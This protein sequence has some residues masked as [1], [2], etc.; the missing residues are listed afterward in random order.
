MHKR[1]ASSVRLSF[2]HFF[3][4]LIFLLVS[5]ARGDEAEKTDPRFTAVDAIFEKAVSTGQIPGAVVLV[6]YKGEIVYRRAFGFRALEPHRQPMTLETV[7]DLASLTK[8][9]AT[10]PS[11]MRMVQ[12]GQVRLNDPV[13]RYLPEF[14][15]NGKE[16]ITVRQLLTHFS[17]LREDLDLKTPW[18]GKQRA[19]EMAFD[20]RPVAPPGSQF[21]YSDINYIAL[22]AV[23]ERISGMS[24]AEYA[25]AHF[26]LPLRMEHTSFLPPRAW[27]PEIAATQ[28]DERG[29]MLRGEVHDPTARRMGGIAGHAGLFS[30]ADDLSRFAQALLDGDKI[31]SPEIIQK[32]TTPQQPANSTI[33]RGLGW[34]IDSPFSSNRGELLPVG[35]YGHTGFTG[36]S[37]WIDPLTQT[38]IIILTNAV[39][40]RGGAN[41]VALR[42]RVA[43]A[44]ADA[45]K[46]EVK[47]EDRAKLAAITGYNETLAG[48]RRLAS[49]N[50]SVLTG[51]D[52]LEAQNFSELHGSKGAAPRRIGVLTNQTGIDSQGRRTIDVL[53]QAPG[54]QLAAIF[55]PEHGATG[56]VDI[57]DIGN[58]VDSGTHVPIYSVY[59]A[60]D[61]QRHPPL[62]VLKDLDAVVIDLQHAGAR[63]YTY[64]TTMGYFL[65]AA[66]KTGIEIIVL[67]RPNPITGSFVQGP[68]S[69]SAHLG[70]VNYYPLPVRHG[71]T[72]GELAKFFNAER[73]L[74]ARLSVVPMQGWMRGDWFDS[75]SVTWVNPSPNL[76]SLNEATLYPGVA[77]A[78]GTNVSVG[79]GTDTPFEVLGA[80]WINSRQLADYLNA[81]NITGIRFIPTNFMPTASGYANQL[82]HGVN[83]VVTDRNVLDSPELGIEL[84]S[85][86][87]T[88]YPN[89]YKM[90]RMIEILANQK[91]FDALLAGEDPRRIA[92]DWQ[93]EVEGFEKQRAQFLIYR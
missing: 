46:L 7:F 63:F 84:A 57:T 34:D 86:L 77:L 36:T 43:T 10:A 51:I 65:E 76:R 49:R 38:Y 72:L 14:G 93:D 3:V 62:D 82:C 64:E 27:L 9:V 8:S 32:M 53:G 59:G 2:T 89:D 45:L 78:E 33:L 88:L 48:A 20:E 67:D 29:I 42:S 54:V 35:S 75:T 5:L 18:Q 30:N 26:F 71:M 17:G 83:M 28:Y 41:A 1:C 11:I 90:D 47:D 6:G 61:A 56:Q 55:S 44:V 15:R 58:S 79:R 50:G 74:N 22:G 21:R 85:A 13:V 39:H 66:A 23:V 52:V 70:F 69:E 73:K 40:P 19:L 12:L 37:I 25:A 68:L 4:F 87:R 31:L 80:P 24:V 92:Q 91:V 16:E 60:A 81:R